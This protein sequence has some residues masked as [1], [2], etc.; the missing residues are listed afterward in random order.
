[1][2]TTRKKKTAAKKSARVRALD[3]RVV[4]LA[5]A[6]LES[7][8]LTLEDADAL[9]IE[10]LTR[11]QTAIHV[12]TNGPLISLK[13]N[14]LHPRTGEPLNDW[15]KAPPY[16]RLR[17]LEQPMGFESMGDKKPLRYVQPFDTAPVAYYPG[18]QDWSE[19]LDDAGVPLVITEGELKAAKACK[20]GF[21]T[22]GLGGVDSFQ[23]KKMGIVWLESLKF[24]N[25]IGRHVYI[26]Y[27]SDMRRNPNVLAALERLAEELQNQGAHPYTVIMP[28]LHGPDTKIGLDDFLVSELGGPEEF[29]ELLSDAEPLGLSRALFHLNDQYVYVR[30]PGF[31]V[32]ERTSSK[33]SPSAFKE[34]VA[35]PSVF[36]AREFDQNGDIRTKT[37]SAAATWI[38]WPLRR[39]VDK[40]TYMPGKPRFVEHEGMKKLNTW[41]GWGVEPRRG[42]VSLFLRLVDHLFVG[43][44]P[45]AKEWFIKWCAYPLQYPG[46]KLFSDVLLYGRR[47]GTGKSLVGYTLGKIYGKNFTEIKQKNL[48]ENHNEWAENKQFV[49]GDDITGS[50]KREDNDLLKNLVTQREMRLNPKYIP[51]YTV[52]DVINY[53]FTGN[54][55]DTFFMDDDDRR[56]FIHE[57]TVGPLPE[58]FY[59]E[60]DL[61]LDSGGAAA[62][63]EYLLRVDT[64]DFNPAGRAF[65]TSAKRRM[66]TETQ[67]DLGAWVRRLVE[68]PDH[69]LR[70]GKVKLKKDLFSNREL[71]ELYDPDKRT[72]TTANGL[73]RELRR[74]GFEMVYEGQS[75]R[76]ADGSERLY[77]IRNCK[78]WRDATHDEIVKHVETAQAALKGVKY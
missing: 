47:H 12:K 58:E 53:M 19:I 33:H 66:I 2:A 43:G 68:D 22:I 26:C 1:M 18:N 41:H 38:K 54:R 64:S 46:V 11:E 75:V 20:D 8:G 25:W 35:A 77:A 72:G 36:I 74:A 40:I 7:S 31:I 3:P 14:Y 6:K 52:P 51:S 48:H 78:R 70:V 76:L 17:Y 24:V 69:T 23:A 37:T 32:D 30:D 10:L 63:F 16:W 61:W 50:N 13:L 39:E 44:D 27:D 5:R 67:S 55:A 73:G 56:H 28:E 4:E 60:Y 34:H 57:V 49:L 29:M 65:D 42:D 59:V 62:L 9:G 15:P 21:P 71:L 45:G